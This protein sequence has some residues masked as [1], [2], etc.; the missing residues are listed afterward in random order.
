MD[1]IIMNMNDNIL[2]EIVKWKYEGK[3]EEYNLES[4]ES[5]KSR[6]SSITL[7]EKSKNY[8]CY[9]K[10]DELVGY[11]NLVEKENGDL[12]LGIGLAPK[13]CGR[14]LGKELLC[15][16]INKAKE[17]HIGKKIVLQVRSW[18]KRAIKC[19]ENIGFK[20]TKVEMQKDYKG[21]E[22]E[23]VFMEYYV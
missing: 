17:K 22:T 1:Y 23:Y 5:L 9:F 6:K 15:D 16:T 2:K 3:Y 4:Y 18:N 7:P 12:F 19:Y 13:N 21:K 8:L 11:T 10:N 14:G 20:I